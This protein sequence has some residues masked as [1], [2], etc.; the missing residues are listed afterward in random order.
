[1]ENL[2]IRR[3]NLAKDAKGKV[4]KRETSESTKKKSKEG[5]WAESGTGCQLPRVW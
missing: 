1:M 5:G 4:A 3:R 2:G